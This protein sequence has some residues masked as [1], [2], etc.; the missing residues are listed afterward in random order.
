M[1][2]QTKV[3]VHLAAVK[4]QYRGAGATETEVADEIQTEDPIAEDTS[5]GDRVGTM[6]SGAVVVNDQIVL[7]ESR[8]EQ[9][10][11]LVPDTTSTLSVPPTET[12]PTTITNTVQN[13]A[14]A[15]RPIVGSQKE[16]GNTHREQDTIPG[17]VDT[18]ASPHGES[19]EPSH[20]V[21]A[22]SVNAQDGKSTGESIPS[23]DELL[24][25]V[26]TK[27]VVPEDDADHYWV[28]DDGETSTTVVL[29]DPPSTDPT[30]SKSDAITPT[31]LDVMPSHF[32]IT[33]KTLYIS[34]LSPGE[35]HEQRVSYL[36]GE[37]PKVA[38]MVPQTGPQTTNQEVE[39]QE[40]KEAEQAAEKIEAERDELERSGTHSIEPMTVEETKAALVTSE[41]ESIGSIKSVTEGQ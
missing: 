30:F 39:I 33:P 34:P 21:E 31:E 5:Q 25:E 41:G 2:R 7:P 36:V 6:Q 40:K 20:D 8:E 3:P 1:E 12:T 24:S 22:T 27:G 17:G 23:D 35:V 37:L 13:D 32:K 10:R 19:T 9:T 29:P 11:Q 14:F 38:I 4:E 18:S 26:N 15:E 28:A 16:D